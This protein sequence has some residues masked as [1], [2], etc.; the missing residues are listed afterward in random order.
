MSDD[1]PP[2]SQTNPHRLSVPASY[3][4]DRRSGK[5]MLTDPSGSSEETGFDTDTA[6]ELSSP[7]PLDLMST[8]SLSLGELSANEL[9]AE[10]INLEKSNLE[11]FIDLGVRCTN[12]NS[13]C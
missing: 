13:Y 10:V 3:A 8:S 2:S 1:S 9:S 4:D 7:P 11:Y 12:S 6:D 5:I